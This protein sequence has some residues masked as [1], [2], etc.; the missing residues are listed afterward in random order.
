MLLKK[1]RFES[2]KTLYFQPHSEDLALKIKK[3]LF[4][5]RA[6]PYAAA[7]LPEKS[8]TLL[9]KANPK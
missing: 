9:L 4:A 8:F 1:I 2:G 5:C 6:E 7:Q 3:S